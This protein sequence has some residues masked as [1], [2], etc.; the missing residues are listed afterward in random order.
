MSRAASLAARLAGAALLGM[1]GS[2]VVRAQ[3][4]AADDPSAWLESA[5]RASR[6]LNYEGVFVYR[7]GGHSET[8]RIAR[9]VDAAGVHERV[10][11]IDGPEREFVRTNDEMRC[12]DAQARSVR[13]ERGVADRPILGTL[14]VD[15]GALIASYRVVKGPLERVAGLECQ[16]LALQPKD[17]LRYG[18]R[19]CVETTSRMILKGAT[20]DPQG[21][22]VEAFAFTQ[23]AIGVP[24]PLERVRS[25]FADQA[26][27]WKV[28]EVA[29]P[30]NGDSGWILQRLP[31]GYQKLAEFRRRLRPATEVSQIV[32]SD[33]LAA[34]SVF[35]EATRPDRAS[36]APV[37]ASRRGAT[38]VFVRRLEDH[39]ITVVGDAPAECVETIANGVAPRPR[40]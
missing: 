13:V 22:P 12:Y 8:S 2:G 23:I 33:G 35:I 18:H 25:R 19:L 39:Q 40:Q 10:E 28:D 15:P 21:R 34:V 7:D 5:Y 11:V 26:R 14:P 38:N 16:A 3:G 27:G 6:A 31:E 17:G 9:R 32:V 37:G 30:A 20:V 1:V 36:S 29:T 4:A 24:V